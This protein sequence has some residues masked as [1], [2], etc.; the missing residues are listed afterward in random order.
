VRVTVPRGASIAGGLAF[1]TGQADWIAAEWTRRHARAE[2]GAGTQV[3][4]R[5]V[6]QTIACTRTTITCGTSVLPAGAAT[7][8]IRAAFQA[9]WRE[10]AVGELPG[11]C[12]ALGE[13]HG[14]RPSRV[15]VRNQQSRWGSCST[16]GNIALNWRLVQMPREVADY[17][18]MHELVHLEHPNHSTRFWRRV[19][20]VCPG[21]RS[22]ERWLRT[23]GR[24]LL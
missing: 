8:G 14:L 3:W 6:L 24:D 11:R 17:V 19:A 5:G 20:A 23:S 1:A 15:Q 10:Q 4:Y 12:C 16:G 7:V 18:M 22:A 21:W 9:L 2:W 13:P